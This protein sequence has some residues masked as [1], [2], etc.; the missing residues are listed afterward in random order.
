MPIAKLAQLGNGVSQA[1]HIAA[2]LADDG[3]VGERDGEV[4]RMVDGA[5]E[6]D[7][8]VAVQLGIAVVAKQPVRVCRPRQGVDLG[9]G[10][11][12]ER[13]RP[14]GEARRE[15]KMRDRLGW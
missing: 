6:L 12:A 1:C 9:Q 5:C 15:F 4:V 7:G 10:A 3:A 13:H 8:S 2:H 11:D 14:G